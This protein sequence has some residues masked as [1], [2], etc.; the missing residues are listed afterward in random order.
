[1]VHLE[2]ERGPPATDSVGWD[3]SRCLSHAMHARGSLIFERSACS[4]DLPAS[5]C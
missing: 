5:V 2:D 3:T 1:M 4:V